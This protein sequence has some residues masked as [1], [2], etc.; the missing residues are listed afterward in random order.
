MKKGSL[1]RH[2]QA[3]RFRGGI[4][5]ES[6]A[7]FRDASLCDPKGGLGGGESMEVARQ[8][9][10]SFE[11]LLLLSRQCWGWAGIGNAKI[12]NQWRGK[13]NKARGNR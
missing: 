2:I 4:S 5:L 12:D 11:L 8:L 7:L 13:S 9:R 6:I 1:P 10:F 3:S